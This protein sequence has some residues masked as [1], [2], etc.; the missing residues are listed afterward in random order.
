M[1]LSPKAEISADIMIQ[2]FVP[3]L[4]FLFLYSNADNCSEVSCSRTE[5][6]LTI[7]QIP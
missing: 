7:R 1:E 5:A 3:Y 2:I 6:L 4:A